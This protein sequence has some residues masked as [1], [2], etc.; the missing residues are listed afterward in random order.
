MKQ[1]H[2]KPGQQPNGHLT[3][4]QVLAWQLNEQTPEQNAHVAECCECRAEVEGLQSSIAAFRSSMF[5]WSEAHE[6]RADSAGVDCASK[7]VAAARVA[8]G[9]CRHIAGR[10]GRAT[11]H[12][13]GRWNSAANNRR[14]SV[15]AQ[16]RHCSSK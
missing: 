3:E 7:A 10:C 11:L 14:S 2:A 9:R 1:Q 5:A 6:S 15:P 12:P 16:I 8:V 13:P 4:E